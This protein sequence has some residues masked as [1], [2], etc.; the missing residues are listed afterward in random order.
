MTICVSEPYGPGLE[1]E[2]GVDEDG[3]GT[4]EDWG[5]VHLSTSV[6]NF[7]RIQMDHS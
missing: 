4:R 5:S 1:S 2:Q 3:E 7:K 6:Q